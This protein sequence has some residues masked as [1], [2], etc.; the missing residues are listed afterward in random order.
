MF[1]FEVVEGQAITDL[2]AGR[3]NMIVSGHFEFDLVSPNLLS[4]NALSRA[5]SR[6]CEGVAAAV[7][8]QAEGGLPGSAG[9]GLLG[10]TEN[11]GT[12]NMR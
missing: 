7:G 4:A 10:G 11:G 6:P 12:P 2:S 3:S 8:R 9:G 1:A 5:G